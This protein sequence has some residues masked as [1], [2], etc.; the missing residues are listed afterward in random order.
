MGQL[1]LFHRAIHAES[2]SRSPKKVTEKG[3]TKI[4]PEAENSF[5][6]T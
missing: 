6:N 1:Q 2:I 5:F 3:V 4:L